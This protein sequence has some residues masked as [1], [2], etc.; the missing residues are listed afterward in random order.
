M[1]RYTVILKLRDKKGK[2]TDREVVYAV[3][4]RTPVVVSRDPYY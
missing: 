4:L 2:V 1:I 3:A